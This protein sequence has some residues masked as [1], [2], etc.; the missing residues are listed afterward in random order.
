MKEKIITLEYTTSATQFVDIT[1]KALTGVHHQCLKF[2]LCLVDARSIRY[3]YDRILLCTSL[4]VC[5]LS[6][7]LMRY[8][9]DILV[10]HISC[11]SL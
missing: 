9:R 7:C 11:V 3:C 4:F 1:T 10:V 6:G 2:K 8:H 5:C